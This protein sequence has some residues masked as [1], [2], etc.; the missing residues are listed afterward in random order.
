MRTNRLWVISLVAG[1]LVGRLS[2]L[3]R[4]GGPAGKRKAAVARTKGIASAP[5]CSCEGTGPGKVPTTAE[6]GQSICG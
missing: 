6:C 1:S 4:E 5:S 3:S 2:G